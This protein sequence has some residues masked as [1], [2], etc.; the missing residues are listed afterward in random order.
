MVH[1]RIIY[2]SVHALLYDAAA[3]SSLNIVADEHWILRAIIAIDVHLTSPQRF[4]F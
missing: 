2:G 4:K 3:R 1:V